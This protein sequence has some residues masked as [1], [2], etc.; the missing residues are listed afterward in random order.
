MFQEILSK[1]SLS[2][3]EV[4]TGWEPAYRD[5]GVNQLLPAYY[6]APGQVI[7]GGAGGWA[8]TSHT[9]TSP[10]DNL[11]WWLPQ[12][13]PDQ[14]DNIPRVPHETL[15]NVVALVCCAVSLPVIICKVE[16]TNNVLYNIN[17]LDWI[18]SINKF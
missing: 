12:T 5:A 17:M 13:A 10:R 14:A 8:G 6:H 2:P 18:S 16:S 3:V 11:S 15:T 4:F 9:V 1:V 7:G